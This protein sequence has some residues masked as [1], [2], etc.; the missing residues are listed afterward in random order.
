MAKRQKSLEKQ[1]V[2]IPN[3]FSVHKGEVQDSCIVLVNEFHWNVQYSLGESSIFSFV[4]KNC[5]VNELQ[6][7]KNLFYPDKQIV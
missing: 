7:H 1:L 5:Q 2:Y 3:N 6:S 4:N